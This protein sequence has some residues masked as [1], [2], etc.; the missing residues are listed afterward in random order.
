MKKGQND[1]QRDL[2]CVDSN[3]SPPL[4]WFSLRQSRFSTVTEEKDER[5]QSSLPLHFPDELSAGGGFRQP[6]S[7][8]PSHPSTRRP[9]HRLSALSVRAA[10]E[11]PVGPR[12]LCVA[13]RAAPVEGS[14]APGKW[15][16]DDGGKRKSLDSKDG[17]RGGG[18]VIQ[19]H[20]SGE[21]R[22]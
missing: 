20:V 10:G 16:E 12:H 19:S 22:S 2:R 4:R 14:S 21:K 17:R 7:R 15:R 8:R 9:L 1:N 5:E 6:L 18:K 11:I 13:R 3:G